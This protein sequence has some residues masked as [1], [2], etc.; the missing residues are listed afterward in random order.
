M[1]L[2][3]AVGLRTL[4]VRRTLRVGVFSTGNELVEPGTPLRPGAIYDSNR[5]LL[6]ALLRRMGVA[7]SDLGV[8]RDDP[9]ALAARL[10]AARP[11]TKQARLWA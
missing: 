7:A 11:V 9:T 2:A 10:S 1:A 8:I 4:K 5:V 3:T 6:L